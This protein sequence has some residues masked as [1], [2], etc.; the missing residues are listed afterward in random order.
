MTETMELDEYLSLT[1]KRGK[2]NKLNNR[3]T[4]VEERWFQSDAEA[5]RYK[6]LELLALLGDI[7]DLRLQ[8]RFELLPEFKRNGEKIR[9]VT[10]TADFAYTRT[11]DGQHVIEDVK[12]YRTQA[13]NIKWKW[14]QYLHPELEF[15]LVPARFANNALL[16]SPPVHSQIIGDAMAARRSARYV[17]R[18]SMAYQTDT[19]GVV[20]AKSACRPVVRYNR[21]V[22]L[23]RTTRALMAN[24]HVARR[25]VSATGRQANT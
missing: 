9:R 7:T 1:K 14:V 11:D 5:Q 10:Y 6:E 3:W 18:V 22:R 13:F 16:T 25:A 2:R 21:S 20:C 19:N 4:K 8:P 24:V 15:V 17:R 23:M 12:G